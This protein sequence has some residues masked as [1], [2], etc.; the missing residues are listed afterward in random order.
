MA[1]QLSDVVAA[2]D[3]VDKKILMKKLRAKGVCES[4]LRLLEEFLGSRRAFV[5]VNG[6]FSQPFELDNMVCQ[7]TVLAPIMWNVFASDLNKETL[8]TDHSIEKIADEI[9]R[10][11]EHEG[12]IP[13]E[14]ILSDLQDCQ[15]K[16]TN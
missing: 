1:V 16:L 5:V 3:R 11:K 8:N 7:G 12:R 2:F 9:K 6:A 14:D 10:Y 13:N 15:M 4:V